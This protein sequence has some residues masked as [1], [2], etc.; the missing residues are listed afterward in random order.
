MKNLKLENKETK[1]G[2]KVEFK[3]NNLNHINV[4]YDLTCDLKELKDKYKNEKEMINH[5]KK[6]F[7]IKKL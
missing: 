2:V 6:D 5:F 1:G 7:I 3:K 4:F